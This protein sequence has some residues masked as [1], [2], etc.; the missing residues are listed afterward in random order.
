MQY[1]YEQHA[2]EQMGYINDYSQ[3]QTGFGIAQGTEDI[4]NGIEYGEREKRNRHEP[5][6]ADC[7]LDEQRFHMRVDGGNDDRGRQIQHRSE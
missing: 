4:E 3:K 5:H 7:I 1:I 2:E 6:V